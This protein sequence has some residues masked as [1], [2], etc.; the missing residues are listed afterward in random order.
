MSTPML[1]EL[2]DAPTKM[3]TGNVS[4]IISYRDKIALKKIG[5]RKESQRSVVIQLKD[6]LAE[7]KRY[8][9]LRVNAA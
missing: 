9:K 1:K 4:S 7:N 3:M 6:N 5:T 8:E 2:R